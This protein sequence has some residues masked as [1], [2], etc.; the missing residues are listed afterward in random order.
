[1]KH[2]HT[3]VNT[4]TYTNTLQHTHKGNL[5]SNYN[6]SHCNWPRPDLV[7]QTHVPGLPPQL[8]KPGTAL[9]RHTAKWDGGPFPLNSDTLSQCNTMMKITAHAL[10]VLAIITS[11]AICAEQ[12]TD[13]ANSQTLE[14]LLRQQAELLQQQSAQLQVL[15]T[16]VRSLE[17]TLAH[18]TAEL[19]ALK[20]SRP[21]QG[22]VHPAGFRFSRRPLHLSGSS[23]RWLC[24]SLGWTPLVVIIYV[25]D[26]STSLWWLCMSLS[27]TSLVVIN[28]CLQV[29]YVPLCGDCAHL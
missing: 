5:S 12:R 15:Q 29:N 24:T 16:K 7:L 14:P 28:G 25:F 9:S 10:L 21:K 18:N 1:M 27:W 23:S 19:A 2:A 4:N 3:H 11:P 6:R 17:A 20:A 8:Y 26:Y 13:D 22:T